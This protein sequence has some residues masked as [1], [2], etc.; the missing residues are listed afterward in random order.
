MALPRPRISPQAI[1]GL[2]AAVA[3]GILLIVVGNSQ[4]A[5][6]PGAYFYIFSIIAI[7]SGLRVITHPL[8]VYAALWF[9]FTILSSCVLFLLLQAEFIA[10][11]LLI[12]YAGAILITYLFVIMLATQAPSEDNVEAL[13]EYDSYSREPLA[14]S[15]VGFVLLAAMT[16]LITRGMGTIE[17]R[18]PEDARELLVHSPRALM[19]AL[20]DRGVFDVLERPPVFATEDENG[21][22][23]LYRNA[24]NFAFQC[25]LDRIDAFRKACERP[26][27]AELFNVG[28]LTAKTQAEGL[29]TA[30][31]EGGGGGV[32]ALGGGKPGVGGGNGPAT[33]TVL[34]ALPRDLRPDNVE[35]VGYSLVGEHPMGLEIAGVVLLMAMLGAVVLARKQIDLTE[36]AK[37]AAAHTL[38]AAGPRGYGDEA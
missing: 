10:F 25:R 27:F 23:S 8:P 32:G 18:H 29:E 22:T 33:A 14:A 17:P 6:R 4:P 31:K 20:D 34:L 15:I 9:I 26:E 24:G 30:K 21:I 12:I 11:A 1:G 19:R 16:T 5:A 37:R 7:L 38:T 36:D 2:I 13:S 3:F 28:N 35:S